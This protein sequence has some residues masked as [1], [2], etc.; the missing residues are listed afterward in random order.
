MCSFLLGTLIV[1]AVEFT[2]GSMRVEAIHPRTPDKVDVLFV[3]TDHYL[4]C[5][6]QATPIA[7]EQST[8][9]DG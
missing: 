6:E 2:P 4:D 8:E 7:G 5:M 9:T 1:G 3:Y